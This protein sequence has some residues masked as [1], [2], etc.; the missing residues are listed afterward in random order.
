MT[1]QERFESI[2]AQLLADR[3]WSRRIRWLHISTRLAAFGTRTVSSLRFAA[4]TW[5]H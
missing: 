1:D 5:V 2:A 3:R 4:D